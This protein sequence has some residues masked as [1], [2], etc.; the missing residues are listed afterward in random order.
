MTR[1]EVHWIKYQMALKGIKQID[2]AS[3]AGCTCPMVS[4]VLHGRKRSVNVQSAFIEI[5][6]YT[7]FNKLVEDASK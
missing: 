3:N 5:L 2:I 1:Q 4:Q 6:G 7:S